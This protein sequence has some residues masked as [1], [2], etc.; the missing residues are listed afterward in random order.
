[1]H[2]QQILAARSRAP[3]LRYAMEAFDAQAGAARV[4]TITHRL[5]RRLELAVL[6][7]TTAGGI[8]ICAV[9]YLEALVVVT[10]TLAT[11]TTATARERRGS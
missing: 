8:Q 11:R 7:V 1:M 4:Q 9:G 2:Q 10:R 3:S 5:T 6:P